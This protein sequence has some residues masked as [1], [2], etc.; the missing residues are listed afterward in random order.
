MLF[1]KPKIKKGDVYAVQ[2]G[3][4]VGQLFNYIEKDGEDYVFL[5]IPEMMIQRVPVDKFDFA[6]EHEII[7]YVETLPR[8]I[9]KVVKA[10]YEE[11]SKTENRNP[12]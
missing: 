11:L 12:K 3:D 2:T 1:F 7:E 8:N 5:S 9:F 4:F 6:K 10:Q